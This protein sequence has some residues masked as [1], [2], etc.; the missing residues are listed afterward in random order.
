MYL[1]DVKSVPIEE[2]VKK[3]ENNLKQ[4]LVYVHKINTESASSIKQILY[5]AASSMHSF[6]K[7]EIK[8]LKVKGLVKE[9]TRL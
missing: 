1:S 2:T 9:N 6:I 5:Y 4:M 8:K 7:N 3:E